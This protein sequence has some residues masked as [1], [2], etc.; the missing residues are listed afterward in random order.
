VRSAVYVI[1]TG[2]QSLPLSLS[3]KASIKVA[4]FALFSFQSVFETSYNRLQ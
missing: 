2:P 1:T 4:K 3:Y